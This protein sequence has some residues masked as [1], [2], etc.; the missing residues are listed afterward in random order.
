MRDS[1]LTKSRH[2]LPASARV[3]DCP[4][5]ALVELLA[6]QAAREAHEKSMAAGT[7]QSVSAE[8]EIDD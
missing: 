7:V 6:Q 8:V 1:E 2:R 3:A 5:R 4:L